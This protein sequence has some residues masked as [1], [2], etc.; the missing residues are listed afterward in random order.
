MIPDPRKTSLGME[1]FCTEGDEIWR[2]SDK[3]L[4]DLARTELVHLGMVKATEVSDGVVFRQP[5][6]YPVYNNDYHRHLQ[7]I[8]DFLSTIENLQTIGRNGLHRY[9]NQDHSMLTGVL[10][11]QNILGARHNLWELGKSLEYFE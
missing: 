3:D 7:V 6:A 1:Y 11:V 10:A 4:L 2:M 8:Q 5:N 9:N